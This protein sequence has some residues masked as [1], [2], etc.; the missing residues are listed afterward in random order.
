VIVENLALKKSVDQSFYLSN[1]TIGSPELAVDGQRYEFLKNH[2]NPE[3]LSR[4]LSL[5]GTALYCSRTRE[6]TRPWLKV[7]F[8]REVNVTNVL[9]TTVNTNP[10]GNVYTPVN[11]PS[12]P[13]HLF[14]TLPSIYL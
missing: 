10:T 9:I 13:S 7:S 14:T 3:E 12:M 4:L 5:N 1:G 8:W 2:K 11:E 6:Q